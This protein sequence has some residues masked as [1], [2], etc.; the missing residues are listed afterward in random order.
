MKL[1]QNSMDKLFFLM[2]MSVK[3]EIFLLSSPLELYSLTVCHLMNIAK[4]LDGSDTVLT[5][6]KTL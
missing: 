4:Y 2:L 3:K 5:I 1:D 6:N